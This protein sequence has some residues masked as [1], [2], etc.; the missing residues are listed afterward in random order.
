[1]LGIPFD[2]LTAVQKK[3][4]AEGTHAPG[5]KDGKSPMTA[6]GHYT[7]RVPELMPLVYA[8]GDHVHY[9]SVFAAEDRLN[10][11]IIL[12][13]AREFTSQ[14]QWYNHLPMAQGAK[15]SAEIID[16]IADGRRP[17]KVAE[18]EE[19]IYDFCV[20]VYR[21]QSV[22]DATYARA[23]AK[24]GEAGIVEILHIQGAYAYLARLFN[25]M[26]HPLPA[27]QTPALAPYPRNQ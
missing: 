16:A 17:A 11:L 19:I 13:S 23:L 2:K 18:D 27:G 9:R 14:F 5:I 8:I 20:E 7:I 26:R 12:L 24:F 1:M 22:S 6:S 4:L 15:L 10:E 21:S 25:V 3:A